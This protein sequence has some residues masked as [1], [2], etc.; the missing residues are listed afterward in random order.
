[1]AG[2]DIYLAALSYSCVVLI[3]IYI[4]MKLVYTS[5]QNYGPKHC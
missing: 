5:G 4:S 2:V 1:M 3:I